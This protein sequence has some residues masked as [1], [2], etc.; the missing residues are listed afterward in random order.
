[1]INYFNT[2]ITHKARTH[3]QE[4]TSRLDRLPLYVA[5]NS[6]MPMYDI[7][8]DSSLRSYR[9]V[10]WGKAQLDRQTSTLF[11]RDGQQWELEFNR[12]DQSLTVHFLRQ[13]ES[14]KRENWK[15]I[16]CQ[17]VDGQEICSKQWMKLTDG[18][19]VRLNRLV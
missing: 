11:T 4:D 1:M 8:K 2:S 16:F 18:H 6:L 13:Y 5:Q 3:V 10:L 14:K 12:H 17:Y 7:E 19:S 9:F 15:W